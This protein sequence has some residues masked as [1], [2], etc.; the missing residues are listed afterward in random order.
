MF[1]INERASQHMRG[2]L[3]GALTLILSVTLSGA[4]DLHIYSNIEQQNLPGCPGPFDADLALDNATLYAQVYSWMNQ[5]DVVDWTYATE[6]P[7]NGTGAPCVL[8]SY[9]TFVQSP[10]FFARLM[11]N[12]HMLVQFP[13]DVRKS[14]CVVDGAVVEAASITVPLIHEL[15]MKTRYEIQDDQINSTI[16]AHYDVPWYIDFLVLDVADHLRANFKQKLDAVAHSLCSHTPSI[17][18]LASPDH[19]YLRGGHGE[20]GGKGRAPRVPPPQ[21][22]PR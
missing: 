7:L 10:T 17:A 15:T 16:D 11:S 21:N 12:L 6:E 20:H 22:R 13:I 14:V 8:V 2:E 1:T 9:K 4:V 19:L 3:L 18:S 5:Q